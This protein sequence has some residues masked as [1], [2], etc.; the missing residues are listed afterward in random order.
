V[1]DSAAFASAGYAPLPPWRDG[2]T[3]LVAQLNGNT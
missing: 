3:R 1:L 2:L